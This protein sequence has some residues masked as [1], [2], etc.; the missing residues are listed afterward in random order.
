MLKITQVLILV[1]E[2]PQDFTLNKKVLREHI[3]EGPTLLES[4]SGKATF[5]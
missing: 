5:G 2:P 3:Q 1:A 4:F